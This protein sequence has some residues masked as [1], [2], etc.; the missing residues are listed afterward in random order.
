MVPAL[1]LSRMVFALSALV[2]Y[3]PNRASLNCSFSTREDTPFSVVVAEDGM[4]LLFALGDVTLLIVELA[5]E[6]AEW[7][8]GMDPIEDA[9]RECSPSRA[10][11]L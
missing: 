9:P 8:L 5:D 3:E 7:R 11:K 4:L 6:E 10:R 1:I 2:L